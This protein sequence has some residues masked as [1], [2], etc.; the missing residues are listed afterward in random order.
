MKQLLSLAIVMVMLFTSLSAL[1][2]A[3]PA[4]STSG[5]P[6]VGEVVEGF[7]VKEVRD[8]P[9]VGATAVLFEHQ[10]TGAGLM[11]VANEDTNRVFDLTFLTRPTDNTGLP[12]VFE[13]ATLY[14]S[15]K[16]PSKTLLFNATLQ[17]YNTFI[18]Q[19]EKKEA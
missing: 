7:E 11:Y 19:F 2:D 9:L 6:A 13:H 15:E 3:L 12:H 18:K 5:I 14:G 10:Q 16:Y 4:A 17:T 1:A 8:F